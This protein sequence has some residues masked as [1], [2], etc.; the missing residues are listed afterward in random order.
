M[1]EVTLERWEADKHRFRPAL[2]RLMRRSGY[3]YGVLGERA[4]LDKGHVWRIVSGDR[5]PK[6]ETARKLARAFDTN[7]G[8]MIE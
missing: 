4:G 7:V 2:R 5:S 3:S 8:E 1:A 6:F